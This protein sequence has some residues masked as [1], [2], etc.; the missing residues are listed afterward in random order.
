MKSSFHVKA[1][2]F[3]RFVENLQSW[4]DADLPLTLTIL[5]K[6][7][8]GY[9]VECVTEDSSSTS[10]QSGSE[11]QQTTSKTPRS[12]V[13]RWR[14]NQVFNQGFDVGAHCQEHYDAGFPC[15]HCED[16]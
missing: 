13:G 6:D 10:P 12:W 15:F 1:E 5:R 4:A 14:E 11:P 7:P 8:E 9:F 3:A 2:S 16:S